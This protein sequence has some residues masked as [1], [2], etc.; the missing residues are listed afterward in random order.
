[1]HYMN[2]AKHYPYVNMYDTPKQYMNRDQ[3]FDNDFTQGVHLLPTD[4]WAE[5]TG[6]TVSTSVL[7]Q[8]CNLTYK[9]SINDQIV[10]MSSISSE[11]LEYVTKAKDRNGS[12]QLQQE[13]EEGDQELRN[14]IFQA[15]YPCLNDLI[16]DSAANYVIQKL[17]EIASPEQQNAL[18]EFFLPIAKIATDHQSGCR[19]L[20]K[21]LENT[22]PEN[23]DR[24]YLKLAPY[25]V[26]LSHSQN[27][28]HI[29][30]RFIIALPKRINE[31][32]DAIQG[33]F[34][35]LVIDNCG[36]RV[37]Q[38]LFECCDIS[39]LSVLVNEVHKDPVELAI[40]QYGNYV[41]QNIL[42]HGPNEDVS[43][44]I[45]SFH[46]HFYDFSIHKFASNV[47]EKCIKRATSE[48][49]N[50]IFEEI[51]G[52]ENNYY[53]H[54][55]DMLVRNQFGNYV[56]QR[57]LEYGTPEQQNAIFEAVNQDYNSLSQEGYAKHVISKLFS[58][59]FNF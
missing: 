45:S 26:S 20:Q 42:E 38:K 40:N 4:L 5:I 21:F 56:I 25:T 54:R 6:E 58:L 35:E 17:C 14:K 44:L 37:V 24:I 23:V 55:I 28:N 9:N 27:G 48:Q 7:S 31:I 16:F 46:G 13:I 57:I 36:C 15:L 2:N 43:K 11:S 39:N 10:K 41:I 22:N 3:C 52:K 50:Y 29:I 33:Y 1:M 51:I 18:L 8:I 47:M 32:V 53:F 49:R 59:G 12:R 19:V 30:Q 34:N